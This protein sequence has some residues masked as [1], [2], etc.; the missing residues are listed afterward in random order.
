M[1]QVRGVRSCSA[2]LRDDAEDV[3]LQGCSLGSMNLGFLAA[4]RIRS[5]G[6]RVD[7]ERS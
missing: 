6:A 4:D 2:T 3:R 1:A 5:F 7:G